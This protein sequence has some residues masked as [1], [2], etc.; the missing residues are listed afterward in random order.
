MW[1]EIRQSLSRCPLPRPVSSITPQMMGFG[2]RGIWNSGWRR[3]VQACSGRSR[4]VQGYLGGFRWSLGKEGEAD[5]HVLAASQQR[6]SKLQQQA[7]M[8]RQLHDS[9]PRGKPKWYLSPMRVLL[10]LSARPSRNGSLNPRRQKRRGSRC[11]GAG[12]AEW[13]LRRATP[14]CRS[15]TGEQRQMHAITHGHHGITWADGLRAAGCVTMAGGWRSVVS[16]AA[17][18]EG[19]ESQ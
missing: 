16:R 1:I 3:Q 18:G 10:S 7:A 11:R 14:R 2:L 15:R 8:I 4:A 5:C 12:G 19:T 9:P 13:L 6:R 17:G